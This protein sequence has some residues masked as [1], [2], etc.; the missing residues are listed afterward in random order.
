MDRFLQGTP[1]TITATIAVGGTS[2]DPSPDT[3]T[4]TVTRDDGTVLVATAGATNTGTGTFSYTLTPAQTALLD[5]LTAAWTVTLGGQSTTFTTRHEIVGGF[6]FSLADLKAVSMGGATTIG[7]KFS[8]DQLLEIRTTVEDTLEHACGRAFVPR[9]ERFTS[10]GGCSPLRLKPFL[11]AIRGVTAGGVAYTTD[12]LAALVFDENGFL[13]GPGD[14][15]YSGLVDGEPFYPAGTGL[16]VRYE[17]GMD[18]PPWRVRKAAL[19]LAQTWIVKGPVDD[20]VTTM[21][22][23]DTGITAALA[24]PGRGGS[25]VG[26]PEVDAVINEYRI[27][28]FA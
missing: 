26:V 12:Q 16:I 10:I 4:V 28:A 2:T 3:A 18:E 22:S 15:G 21:S 13:Y 25:I 27:P 6:L 7:A 24:V 20:R 9:Y 23:P 17:H 11:R 8:N 1:A 5:R 19:L 14:Y